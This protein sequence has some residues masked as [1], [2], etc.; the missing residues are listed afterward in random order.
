VVKE[1]K[2]F[3]DH[4]NLLEEESAKT[5]PSSADDNKK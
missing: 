5:A 3:D 1:K 4:E 2:I